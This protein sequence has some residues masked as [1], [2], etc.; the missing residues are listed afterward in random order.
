MSGDPAAPAADEPVEDPCA[1]PACGAPAVRH[2]SLAEARRAYPELAESGRRAP[3][4]R[5][6]YKGWKK[7]TKE[8]RVLDRLGR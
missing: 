3:L 2:L 5:E 7:A 4:C 6:H 1:V 8:A